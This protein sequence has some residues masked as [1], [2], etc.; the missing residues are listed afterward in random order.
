LKRP[1]VVLFAILM[2][3]TIVLEIGEIMQR[4]PAAYLVGLDTASAASSRD[5]FLQASFVQYC[6]DN[7]WRYLVSNAGGNPATQVEQCRQMIDAGVS[8]LIVSAQDAEA[9]RPIARYA[10]ARHVPVFATDGDIDSADVAMYVGFSG[11]QAGVELARAI[12]ADLK[13]HHGGDARGTVLEMR[14]PADSMAAQERSRGFH[15]VMD[16][17]KRVTVIQA[18]GDFQEAL[19]R[20]R[21]A[22]VLR[23]TPRIDACYSASGSMAAG[24]VAALKDLGRNPAA[25]FTVTIDATPRVLDL[26]R[27]GD[28][29]AA[30][31]QTPGFYSAIAAHYLVEYLKRGRAGLPKPGETV[32]A[33]GLPLAA[34]FSPQRLD[35]WGNRS[36]WAPARVVRGLAGHAWFQTGAVIVTKG[37]V[38]APSLWANIRLQEKAWARL[39]AAVPPS[40]RG[41]SSTS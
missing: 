17:Q 6:K 28:I 27:A 13:A 19:S 21:A 32:S 9:A 4:R 30:A 5:A 10:A 24:V 41:G 34:G 7:R 14:G 35:I 29:R 11:E 31:G 12:V 20:A 16:R 33:A 40:L 8:G 22:R 39:P 18:E 25:V 36:P 3:S 1:F 23:R 38:D 15:E 2:A 37:N 26:I